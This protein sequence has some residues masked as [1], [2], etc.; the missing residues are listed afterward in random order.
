MVY[1]TGKTSA[2]VLAHYNGTTR[3]DHNQR[4]SDTTNIIQPAVRRQIQSE[5][6]AVFSLSV[7]KVSE[8]NERI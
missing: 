3:L 4:T 2:V 7:Y 1:H 5:Q 6:R 8:R